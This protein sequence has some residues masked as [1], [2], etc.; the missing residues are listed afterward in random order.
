M[1]IDKRSN[2]KSKFMLA[3]IAKFLSTVRTG[4]F[5]IYIILAVIFVPSGCSK[6]DEVA[7]N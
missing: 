1:I 5:S 3:I 6:K 7:K 4:L 2:S